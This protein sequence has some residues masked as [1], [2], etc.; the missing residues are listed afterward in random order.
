[1]AKA[2]QDLLI[3]LGAGELTRVVERV[4]GELGWELDASGRD[5]LLVHEDATRLHCH[6]AP[7]RAEVELGEAGDRRTRLTISGQ[8]SGW[9]PV[10]SRHVRE[11][12]D[13]LA[14][15]IGL[16]AVAEPTAG[17]VRKRS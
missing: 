9:G 14:R 1:M 3:D 2:R 5:G 10:A 12:T 8:V 6:C 13:L 7:I 16:A 11:Q 17:E 15:R 4:V